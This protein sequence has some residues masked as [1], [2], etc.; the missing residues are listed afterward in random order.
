M[1][2]LSQNLEIYTFN[3]TIR[4]FHA[5]KKL[6]LHEPSTTLT[7]YMKGA[8][9]GSIKIFNKLPDYIA[10]SV[11]KKKCFVWNMEKYLTDKALHSTEEYLNS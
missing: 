2:F 6:Q 9:N 8:Y 5:R 11:L 3:S 1:R 4:G 7:K 10:E